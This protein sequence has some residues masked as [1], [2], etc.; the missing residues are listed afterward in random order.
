MPRS[1]LTKQLKRS[2]ISKIKKNYYMHSVAKK[3]TSAILE[4]IL[5]NVEKEKTS[6]RHCQDLIQ[7]IFNKA[8]TSTTEKICMPSTSSSLGSEDEYDFSWGS[9]DEYKE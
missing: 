1:N 3:L 4:D 9:I 8:S 6:T 7:E 5:V 2:K